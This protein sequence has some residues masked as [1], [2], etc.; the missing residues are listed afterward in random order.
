MARVEESANKGA[1]VYGNAQRE[2]SMMHSCILSVSYG[3]C[4]IAKDRG[5]KIKRWQHIATD[6]TQE[7][8][9]DQ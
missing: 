3:W 4:L 2:N 7:M 5:T 8:S 9:I 6:E 1:G